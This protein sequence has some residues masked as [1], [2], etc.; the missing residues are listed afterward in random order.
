[1]M[2]QRSPKCAWMGGLHRLREIAA[3]PALLAALALVLTQRPALPAQSNT[4]GGSFPLYISMPYSPQIAKVAADGSVTPLAASGLVQPWSLALD[5]NNNLYVGDTAA[6]QIYKFDAGGNQSTVVSAGAFSLAFDSAG[7][8]YFA[9]A[10]GAVWK[11]AI[12]GTPSQLAAVCSY[13]QQLPLSMAFDNTGNLFVLC[14]QFNGTAPNSIFKITG[15]GTAALFPVD[16]SLVT[17]PV[18]LAFDSSGNLYINNQTSI[19]EVDT[20]GTSTVFSPH[21]TYGALAF[22][23]TG[24]LYAADFLN[25]GIYIV[26]TGGGAL[27]VFSTNIYP[28]PMAFSHA[29]ATYTFSGFLAPISGPPAVNSG[30]AGQTYP[31]KWQ[32][33]DST[34]AFV[35][36]LAAIKS[37]TYQSVTCGSFTGTTVPLSTT[38]AGSSSLRYDTTANQYVYNWA[39]PNVPGC[40]TLTVAFDTGQSFTADFSLR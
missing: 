32:L 14:K 15:D 40:Y 22:D 36:T 24:K 34:G 28:F 6:N 3:R 37:V 26:P 31:V 39:T 2:T 5:A 1:M 29:T 20:T 17:S 33:K 11:T 21:G 12:G 10:G 4:L 27:T 13:G 25:G 18:S 30:K 8:L 9:D 35:T 16:S 23:A 7:N 38:A 19:V